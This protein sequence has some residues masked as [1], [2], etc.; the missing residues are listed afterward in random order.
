VYEKV[1]KGRMLREGEDIRAEFGGR[2]FRL[3]GGKMLFPILET[4][5]THLDLIDASGVHYKAPNTTREVVVPLEEVR[6]SSRGTNGGVW[7]WLRLCRPSRR[8]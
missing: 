6:D 5:L 4:L 8:R 3:K 1:G 7:G 2:R